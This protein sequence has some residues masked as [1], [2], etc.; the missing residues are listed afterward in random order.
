[1]S[2]KTPTLS[3]HAIVSERPTKSGR[4]I[5]VFRA[6]PEEDV[7]ES[8]KLLDKRLREIGDI[9]DVDGFLLEIFGSRL[10]SEKK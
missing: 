9:Y 5:E 2:D 3:D 6:Y 4:D 8:L 1:M 10:T 7:R